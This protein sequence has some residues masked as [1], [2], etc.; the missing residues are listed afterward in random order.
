MYASGAYSEK[1]L[2]APWHA[3]HLRQQGCGDMLGPRLEA[4]S[5][6]EQWA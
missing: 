3:A 4:G 1:V 5:P 6:T 2:A